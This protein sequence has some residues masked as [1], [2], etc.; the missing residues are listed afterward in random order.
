MDFRFD[1]MQ[2]LT[3]AHPEV[4]DKV[5]IKKNHSD[6]VTTSTCWRVYLL[7]TNAYYS[8]QALWPFPSAVIYV[9]PR[10]PGYEKK[11]SRG[12]MIS[13]G[14]KSSLDPG[15]PR[16]RREQRK[17]GFQGT[18]HQEQAWPL[19]SALNRG[20]KGGISQGAGNEIDS[21]IFSDVMG[22]LTIVCC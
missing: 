15:P 8:V 18:G 12:Q 14:N 20:T 1:K 17:E 13:Q 11:A 19:A 10:I 21:F 2:Q 4:G 16:G 22:F 9:A 7:C 3:L 5:H 6:K